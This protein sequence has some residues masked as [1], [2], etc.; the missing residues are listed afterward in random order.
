MHIMIVE[1]SR[2]QARQLQFLMEEQGWT[3]ECFSTAEAALDHLAQHRPDLIV[4]DYH[5]PRMNGDELARILR[6]NVQTRDIPLV[7]LTDAVGRET[8]QRGLDRR[9]HV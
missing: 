9:A 8:E 2:T 4:V 7:M 5:L 3:A 1:D 6:I